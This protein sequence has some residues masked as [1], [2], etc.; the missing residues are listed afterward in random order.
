VGRFLR[1]LFLALVL[2]AGAVAAL[3]YLAVEP[4]AAVPEAPPVAAREVERLL[5]ENDPRRVAGPAFRTLV[6]KGSEID[7]ILTYLARWVPGGRAR[8]TLGPG[9]AYATLTLPLP[10]NPLGR[11]LNVK[12]TVRARGTGLDLARVSLGRVPIPDWLTGWAWEQAQARLAR[13]PTF[14]IARDAV[15]DIR[16]GPDAVRVRYEWRPEIAEAARDRL[17][18]AADQAR[19]AAYG[20]RLSRMLADAPGNHGG[21]PLAPVLR[22]LLEAP[23][24]TPVDPLAENR[25]LLVV[26]AAHALG[27]DLRVLAPEADP[28]AAGRRPALLLGGRVDLAQHFLAS[29]ALAATAG[30]ELADAVGLS[31]ELADARG[32]SGFS[33]TDLAADRAG[34]RFGET[35]S[36]SPDSAGAWRARLAEG[37]AESDL[38][39]PV[40]DLPEFLPEA[41]FRRRYGQVDSPAYRAVVEEIERRV[42]ALGFYR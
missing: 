18:P 19:I 42:A 33:F 20:R 1:T 10:E 31:K 16:I 23:A 36:R 30:S 39:P 17:V 3:A 4:T 37:P 9:E 35:A 5:R 38:M 29:A 8:V 13:D 28:P 2:G 25:A 24:S 6:L 15:R 7:A 27:R 12:A 34:T 11:F 40:K 22:A 14:R 32:G 26:L 21:R 41:E